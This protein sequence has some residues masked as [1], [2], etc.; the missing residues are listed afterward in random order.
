MLYA[1]CL[2]QSRQCGRTRD[3]TRIIIAHFVTRFVWNRK[4]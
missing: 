3:Y 4:R 2:G 1:V